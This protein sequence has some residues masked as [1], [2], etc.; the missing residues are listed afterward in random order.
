MKQFIFS[1]ILALSVSTSV[2][3]NHWIY[4]AGSVKEDEVLDICSDQSGNIISAGYFSGPINFG[5][6]QILNSHSLGT[7]DIFISKSNSN[8]Q[9]LWSVSAGGYGSDRATDVT[10]DANGNIYITGFYYGNATFGNISVSSVNSSQDVFIAKIDAN[11]NFIWVKS[12]GGNLAEWGNAINTDKSGNIILTGQFQGT[13]NFNGTTVTSA[14]N[15]IL[16][17]ASFDVFTA[18]LDPSGNIIWLKTGSSKF[19]DRGL[20]LVTDKNRNIYVCGQF[21]D[22]ITFNQ[23]HNNYIKN[24]T[25]IIKYDSLGNEIWCKKAAGVFSIPYSLALDNNDNLYVTGDFQGTLTYFGNSSSFINGVNAKKT[26]LIKTNSNGDF[27]WGKS[28]SS[29]NFISSKKVAIDNQQ[30]PYILGE[31]GCTLSEY[32]NLTSPALFNSIGF[33]DFFLTKYDHLGNRL[34]FKHFGGPKNDKAHGLII[35]SVNEPV[36]SG[37]YEYALNIPSNNNISVINNIT[38]IIKHGPFQTP[39]FC[40]AP[41][42]YNKYTH[43]TSTG[44]SDGFILKGFDLSRDYYD[45][46]ERNSSMCVKDFVGSCINLYNNTTI[47]PDT[48]NICLNDSIYADTKTGDDGYYG[49]LHKFIWNNNTNDSLQKLYKNTSG[50]NTVKVSTIDGCYSS[51]DTVYVSVHTLPQIPLLTDNLGINNLQTKPGIPLAVCVPNTVTLTANNPQNLQVNW[52]S[53]NNT[54]INSSGSVAHITSSADYTVVLT[55]QF[56]CQDSNYV[57]VGIDSILPTFNPI[58]NIDS[59]EICQNEIFTLAIFDSISNP[60]GIFPYSTIFHTSTFLTGPSSLNL[61]NPTIESGDLNSLSLKLIADTTGLYNFTINYVRNNACMND[62]ISFN[63]QLFIN[64]KPTPFANLV[65]S[66]N[67]LM[68]PGDSITITPSVTMFNPSNVSYTITP[69]TLTTSNEGAHWFIADLINTTSQCQL[70]IFD[71]VVVKNKP[72]PEIISTPYNAVICP[73]DSILLSINYPTAQSYI[74]HGPTGIINNNSSSLFVK[75]AGFY[76]CVVTDITGCVFITNTLEIKNYASPFLLNHSSSPLCQNQSTTIQ[77]VTLDTTLISWH[78]PLSGNSTNQSIS[79]P[80]IYLCEVTMCNITSSLSINVLGSTQTA[81]INLNGP[82]NLCPYDSITVTGN[83]GMISYLWL[84]TGV[85]DASYTIHTPGSYSLETIDNYGCTS[86]SGELTVNHNLGVINP[87]VLSDT[88]C[89]GNNAILTAQAGNNQIDWFNNSNSGPIIH[90]GTTFSVLNITQDSIFYASTV[91]SVGCHSIGIPVE[92]IINPTS[93]KPVINSDSIFCNG[94]SISFSTNL[95]QNATYNWQGPGISSSTSIPNFIIPNGTPSNSGLY[96]LNISGNGCV[97]SSDSISI[98]IIKPTSPILSL[99]DSVCENSTLIIP[100]ASNGSSFSWSGPN[101]FQTISDSLVLVS[102]TLSQSGVYTVISTEA[103]CI[104]DSSSINIKIIKTPNTPI[105][106][107][108]TSYCIGDTIKLMAH[109]QANYILDWIGPQNFTSNDSIINIITTNTLVSG[110]YSITSINSI[111]STSSSLSVQVFSYPT[112]HSTPDTVACDN[113]SLVLNSLSNYQNYIWNTGDTT[114]NISV[115]QNGS[116]WVTTYNGNCSVTDTIH[117]SLV[118]CAQIVLNAFSPNGD[119]AN[120]IFMFKTEGIIDLSCEIRD[121]W[122]VKIAE[123]KGIENGWDGKSMKTN[124]D[125]EEGSYFYVLEYKTI[126]G[127][128]KTINGFVNLFR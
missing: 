46:Y 78:L 90:S 54:P 95:V 25:F 6:G 59:I 125:C 97:S 57:Y 26:F 72:N 4:S 24:A 29:N 2:S 101:S 107:G 82:I 96:I 51:N 63:K 92:I 68:C 49:P 75:T 89:Y 13:S 28:E 79:I 30:N 5:N 102:T 113:Q 1:I 64:V 20:D 91:D 85:T 44:Y 36:I 21:S 56:G 11:G 48:I 7:A 18:K 45:Y 121:R 47:C 112:L 120:D 86:T 62:T 40:S 104:G 108:N 27:I 65:F 119:G 127:V 34:W 9:V 3:Q 99:N 87:T 80:G 10:V 23:T 19:D 8:G 115:N 55:N 94:D 70:H 100:L 60:A 15:P 22:T 42:N 84:P 83:Q 41:N 122:G 37:S 14:H 116:Y 109:N 12:F 111:C 88:V 105:I 81:S 74:W 126:E 103:G 77:V 39:N 61:L 98:E 123:F 33:Q 110:T 124:Q 35:N 93:I 106:S 50:Y 69:N 58:C 38:T 16:N 32:S 76:H 31:F 73:N 114:A 17:F 66:G 67:T 128:S 43:L 52:Y 117:V 118:P 53:S 71:S